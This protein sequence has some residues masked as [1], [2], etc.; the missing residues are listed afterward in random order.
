MFLLACMRNLRYT[1]HKTLYLM[2]GI[3]GNEKEDV[4]TKGVWTCLP[5][6]IQKL[7]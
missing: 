1:V 4:Y 6:Q 7:S 3:D 2:Q 5:E